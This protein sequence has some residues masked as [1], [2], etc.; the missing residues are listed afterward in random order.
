MDSVNPVFNLD[1]KKKKPHQWDQGGNI[2]AAHVAYYP[3]TTK[4]AK[5]Y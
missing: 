1:D 3:L 5:V 2:L 4:L